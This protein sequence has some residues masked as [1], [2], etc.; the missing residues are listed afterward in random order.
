MDRNQ[1]QQSGNKQHKA[2]AP[3][4]EQNKKNISIKYVFTNVLLS[5]FLRQ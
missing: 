4:V 1:Q 2:I 5:T 3:S